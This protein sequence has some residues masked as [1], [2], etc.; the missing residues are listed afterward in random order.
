MSDNLKKTPLNQ[1]HYDLGAKMVDFGGWDMPVQY[2]G[3][4]DEH[5][6]VRTK[7]G[8][9]DV[10]HMGEFWITGKDASKFINY[11]LS[12]SVTNVKDGFIKYGVLML[13]TGKAVDDLLAYKFND[14]KYLLVPNASNT[15]K[16]YQWILDHKDGFDVVFEDKSDV[17][18]EV[19]IQGPLAEK[20]LQKIT[21]INLKDIPFYSFKVGKVAGV[22]AIVSRT[23][24]TGEDGFEI[25]VESND[26]K[27]INIVWDKILEVSGEDIKPAG[28]GC[29]DTLR[30]EMKLPLYGHEL[31]DEISPLET[32]I[33]RF[34][35]LDKDD[36]IGKDALDKEKAEGRKRKVVGLEMVGRGIARDD[37]PV[38][39][40]GNVVGYITSGSYS[41]SLKK[42]LG[43]ALVSMDVAVDDKI[44]VEIRGKDV[45][46]VVVKTPFYKKG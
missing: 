36:F 28:L 22:E 30:F 14:E 9:F 35:D 43:L 7:S 46:A 12:S 5:E 32:G 24:Y 25:Y 38:K 17:T 3:I 16:D 26:G 34:V 1:K 2:S 41:P 40:D 8:L 15:P 37:Y 19:A 45:E 6:A 29:R 13:P 31:S 18:G 23:G 42:N 33:G 21:D 11:L 27:D 39:K 10:S 4:L 44:A 20:I